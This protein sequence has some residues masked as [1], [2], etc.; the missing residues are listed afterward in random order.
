MSGSRTALLAFVGTALMSAAAGATTFVEV[1]D[2]ELLRSSEIVLVGTVTGV[3]ASEPDA[4]GAIYTY[5]HVQPDRIIKGDLDGGPVV[6]REPGGRFGDQEERIF[7]APE[8]WTGERVLLFLTRNPDG[9]LRTNNLSMGKY[10][11][12]IDIRGRQTASRDFGDEVTLLVPETGALVGAQPER[13][14]LLPLLRRLRQA[15]RAERGARHR[16]PVVTV[17]PELQN[18]QTEVQESFTF[19]SSPPARW[20]EPDGGQ[21]VSY[22]VESG[23]DAALGPTVS[24]AAVDAAFAAWTNVNGASITLQD[25]GT[26]GSGTFSG[27]TFNRILFNDPSSEI[28]DPSNCGGI[29]AIGGYCSSGE[30]KVVNGTTFN[31]IVIG[32]VMFNNG[33]GGCSGWNQCNLAE[34]ATHEIGHTIGFGHSADNTATMAAVA[35]WDG[36]CASL[37]ADDIA[38]AQFIYPESGPTATPTRT[39]PATSTPTRTP[40]TAPTRTPTATPTRSA[41]PTRTPTSSS[42]ATRTPTWTPTLTPT[43]TPT[44]T[45]TATPTRSATPSWTPTATLTS[46]RTSTWTPTPTPTSTRT[47]TWTPTATPPATS[48][49]TPTFTLT[50]T[51]TDAPL[52]TST[53]TE[54]PALSVSGMVRYY[55][56]QLPV[57]AVSVEMPPDAGVPTDGAGQYAYNNLDSQM[58]ELMPMKRGDIGSAVSSLDAAYVL[59]SALGLRTLSPAQ[60]LAADVTGNGTISSLDASRI[61]QFKVGIISQFPVAATCGSDWIFLPQPLASPNQQVVPPAIASGSCQAGAIVFDPLVASA[62]GQDFSA[63]AFGDVTGNW[64]P[65]G[66]GA[67]TAS[68]DTVQVRFGHPVPARSGRL[69][70]PVYVEAPG[71]FYSVDLQLRYAPAGMRVLTVQQPHGHGVL[72]F[73]TPRPGALTVAMAS[74]TPLSPDGHLALM[75]QLATRQRPARLTSVELEQITIDRE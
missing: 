73:N 37:A 64:Q 35:H 1:D 19:L 21:P 30:S 39:S 8:F 40:T 67:L 29:L 17:P 41:S 49:A 68:A 3:E 33:W 34:V 75:V 11:L 32:K 54:T 22:L 47:P 24:R 38:G 43:A 12:G 27:C 46:T 13:K 36:R 69:R 15:A 58:H 26:T 14:R 44:R 5:V 56:N 57:S 62:T 55:S 25:G 66:G 48:T 71:P 52:P 65:A 42:T 59:Q 53:P 20:F 72:A 6:L 18:V 7:G 31:R 50:A 60:A 61:L 10:S 2:A 45:P 23:G 4:T 74:A 28:T 70:V 51:P 63:I 9:T 16:R